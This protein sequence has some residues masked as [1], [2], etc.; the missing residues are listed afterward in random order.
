MLLSIA[1]VNGNISKGLRDRNG[2]NLLTARIGGW[3]HVTTARVSWR[4]G[5][6]TARVLLLRV[7]WFVARVRRWWAMASRSCLPV[8]RVVGGLLGVRAGSFGF[9][10]TS[11]KAKSASTFGLALDQTMMWLRCGQLIVGGLAQH[12]LLSLVNR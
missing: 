4:C 11:A 10:F 7:G 3:G 5:I 8:V 2:H 6:I 1:L 9:G 12:L